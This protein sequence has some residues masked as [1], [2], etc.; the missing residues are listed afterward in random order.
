MKGYFFDLIW[1]HFLFKTQFFWTLFF[2]SYSLSNSC[3]VDSISDSYGEDIGEEDS[4]SYDKYDSD[5]D[6]YESDF[7]DDGDLETVPPSPKYKSSGNIS[8]LALSLIINFEGFLNV[9]N[10]KV[11]FGILEG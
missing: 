1:A 8:S 3:S 5:E 10:P 6:K 11:I 4:S 7:I 2:K 9:E